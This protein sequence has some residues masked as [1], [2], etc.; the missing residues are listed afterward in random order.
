MR[1]RSASG[2]LG[3]P[4]PG[5][6]LVAFHAHPDDESL[7]TGG[8]LA[9]AVA[10]GHRA[11]VIVATTGGLGLAAN[12]Q[13][14]ARRRLFE[15]DAAARILGVHRV[16]CLDYGDSGYLEPAT[17]PPGSLC[18]ADPGEVAERVAEI[19]RAE[20]ADVVTVYDGNGGYGH[21]DHRRVF[22]VG[23][24][25]AAL[26]GTGLVLGATVDRRAITRGVRLLNSMRVRPG[27]VVAADLADAF[28]APAE[29]THEVDVRDWVRVKQRAL[30]AH[31]SQ[32]GGAADVRVVR[33][34]GGLPAVLARKVLGREWFIELDA[35]HVPNQRCADVFRSVHSATVS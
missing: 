9:K 23:R 12:A 3:R 21:R 27:G 22:E 15:L 10:E 26:A 25:A 30:R 19:L 2:A 32:S 6:T 31:G 7:F 8:V 24:A 1:P 13:G 28:T 11:V 17:P 20:S 16:H 34:L 29:I 33:L 5:K 4:A 18:A 14:L 35:R